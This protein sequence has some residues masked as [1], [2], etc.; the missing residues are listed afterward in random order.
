MTTK[1]VS[2]PEGLTFCEFEA[3]KLAVLGYTNQQIAD[4]LYKSLETVK[5]QF[6]SV[7]GK[8]GIECGNKRAQLVQ[9]YYE[10]GWSQMI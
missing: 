2:Y 4:M 7:Y 9:I 3:V 6:T 1:F 10:Q 5:T 8:L